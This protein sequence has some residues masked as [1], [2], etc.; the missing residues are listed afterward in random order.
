MPKWIDIIQIMEIYYPPLL[1][2]LLF[3][4]STRRARKNLKDINAKSCGCRARETF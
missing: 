3:C 2:S 4:R 1:R